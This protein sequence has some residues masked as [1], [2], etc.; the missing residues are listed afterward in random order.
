MPQPAKFTYTMKQLDRAFW[1][2]VKVGAAREGVSVKA[3]VHAALAH[4]LGMSTIAAVAAEY[5]AS[6]TPKPPLM[7]SQDDD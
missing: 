5:L 2:E 1:R 4:R 3:F 6:L 7:E